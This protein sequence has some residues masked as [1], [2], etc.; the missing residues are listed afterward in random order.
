MKISIII[1]IHKEDKDQIFKMK[2]MLMN[3]SKIPNEILF[4]SEG[5]IPEARNIGV[6]KA[7]KVKEFIEKL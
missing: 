6:R 4:I 7:R 2:G 1:P 3:Q 5:T